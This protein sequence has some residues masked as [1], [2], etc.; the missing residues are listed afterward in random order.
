M[1]VLVWQWTCA[2]CAQLEH[3]EVAISPDGWATID[4]QDWHLACF[5][6]AQNPGQ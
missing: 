3:T 1:A 4:G 2:G 5:A 6:A